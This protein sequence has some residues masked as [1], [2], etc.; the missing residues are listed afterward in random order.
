MPPARFALSRLAPGRRD[1][2]SMR[3]YPGDLHL[4]DDR[5]GRLLT[6]PD[7]GSQAKIVLVMTVSDWYFSGIFSRFHVSLIQNFSNFQL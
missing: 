2:R 7:A 4:I 1:I 5:S 3:G 6:R